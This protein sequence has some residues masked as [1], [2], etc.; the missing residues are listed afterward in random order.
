MNNWNFDID[1][2]NQVVKKGNEL[3]KD[4]K[5]SHKKRKIIDKDIQV[6]KQFIKGDFSLPDEEV[7]HYD[8]L[9]YTK[10][11]NLFLKD[12]KEH[13]EFL[14]KHLID[15]IIKVYYEH[16]FKIENTYYERPLPFDKQ[17]YL[18]LKN[19][20]TVSSKLYEYA[21]K[22]V[23]NNSFSQI[24]LVDDSDYSSFCH[25]SEIVK[26]PFIIVDS[27]ENNNIF[28]HELQHAIEDVLDLKIPTVYLELGSIE[29]EL[30][31][32]D[33]L[34]K[35]KN[36]L[37]SDDYGDRMEET[38]NILE[39]LHLYLTLLKRLAKYDFKINNDGFIKVCSKSMRIYE[40][41]VNEWLYDTLTN[42]NYDLY[43]CYLMSYLKAIEIRENQYKYQ[44]D[45]LH[46]LNQYYKPK[47]VL[48]IPEDG[49]EIYKRYVKEMN[50][51]TKR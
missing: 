43:I 45:V 25:Y 26:N 48:Q 38:D 44:G 22:I 49:I 27:E 28:N 32:N 19:Y 47:P 12:A 24:Q 17:V 18:T 29:L 8:G 6:F 37:C 21:K 13:Y 31:F 15:Y 7:P 20:N 35:E 34:F 16:I 51:K 42:C 23:F 36:Y 2:L 4:E 9:S 30:L 33:T 39:E 50:E 40:E 11:K 3:L 10:L 41:Q 1:Y 46:L 14:G 5:L